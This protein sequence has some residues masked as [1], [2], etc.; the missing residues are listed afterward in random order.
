MAMFQ[1]LG[2][3]IKANGAKLE[4]NRKEMATNKQ[5]MKADLEKIGGQTKKTMQIVQTKMATDQQSLN[6]EMA[7]MAFMNKMEDRQ[8]R[9]LAGMDTNP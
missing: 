9:M 3:K 5:K 7:G 1:D 2:V 6:N 4:I 8:Y